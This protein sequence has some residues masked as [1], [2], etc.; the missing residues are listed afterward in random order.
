MKK[1]KKEL[2]FMLLE[3]WEA[4]IVIWIY[5]NLQ[6]NHVDRRGIS[7]PLLFGIIAWF[8]WK[9]RCELSV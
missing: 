1:K 3:V 6:K 5:Y 2:L 8:I 9:D 7:W 4:F